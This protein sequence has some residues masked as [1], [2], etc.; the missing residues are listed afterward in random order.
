MCLGVFPWFHVPP[1]RSQQ[2]PT[3]GIP[4][5]PIARWHLL[6]AELAGALL[7][8][9]FEGLVLRQELA[10]RRHHLPLRPNQATN[11]SRVEPPRPPRGVL[12]LKRRGVCFCSPDKKLSRETQ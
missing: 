9:Q 11:P 2:I 10:E 7:G 3:S 12:R 6:A 8:V 5:A 1:P 4:A